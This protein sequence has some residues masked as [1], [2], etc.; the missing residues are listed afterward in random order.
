MTASKLI[1]F[2]QIYTMNFYER[3]G[4]INI[5][6]LG[7]IQDYTED[8]DCDECDNMQA[9]YLDI[10][11]KADDFTKMMVDNRQKV[12]MYHRNMYLDTL[13]LTNNKQEDERK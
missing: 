3:M 11:I 8:P 5:E 7:T 12:E 4:T 10:L 13:T 9:V 1:H 2:N 6:G